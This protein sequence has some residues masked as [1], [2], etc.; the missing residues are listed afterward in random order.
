MYDV[1]ISSLTAAN[2][3]VSKIFNSS[4]AA[5]KSVN[6]IL[7][8]LIAAKSVFCKSANQ[9]YPKFC[10]SV[11]QPINQCNPIQLQQVFDAANIHAILKILH[12][13][14]NS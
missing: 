9:C 12:L 10:K 1:I 3:L 7:N 2:Q 8:S 5:N 6:V 14:Q 4:T 11:N 13:Q